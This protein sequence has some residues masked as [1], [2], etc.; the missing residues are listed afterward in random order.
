AGPAA[1]EAMRTRYDELD[2]RRMEGSTQ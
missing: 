2:R 1:S